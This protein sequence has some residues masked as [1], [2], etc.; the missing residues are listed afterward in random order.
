LRRIA[1]GI[2]T[3]KFSTPESDFAAAI[4]TLDAKTNVARISGTP[5]AL[6]S[7]TLE[8]VLRSHTIYFGLETLARGLAAAQITAR[9]LVP[10]SNL[11][12]ATE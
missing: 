3:R 5:A 1:E 11:P 2:L 8:G 10:A 7:Q 4:H 9:N 12:S 6:A